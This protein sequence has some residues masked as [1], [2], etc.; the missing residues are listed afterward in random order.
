MPFKLICAYLVLLPFMNLP[1]PAFMA[2]KLQYADLMFIPIMAVYIFK[3]IKGKVRIITDSA[4]VFLLLFIAAAALSFLNSADKRASVLDTL[5]IV[6]LAAMYFVF[7]HF[8]SDENKIRKAAG[9]IFGMASIC[10]ITGLI[11]FVCHKFL[12]AGWA[13]N[14]LFISHDK[15]AMVSSARISSFLKMPEMFTAYML[16][17]LA[18]GFVYR[19][20]L[21]NA[22][23]RAAD[24]IIFMI[25]STCVLSFSR[26]LAG[27]MLFL[28]MAS[29]YFVKGSPWKRSVAVACAGAFIFTFLFAVFTSIFMV[30]PVECRRNG[31]NGSAKLNV[32]LNY[33][34]RVYLAKAA[35]RISAQHPFVG[36]GPGS[37]SARFAQ[38]LDVNETLGLAGA[39]GVNLSGLAVDPHSFYFGTIAELGWP[40]FSIL[41]LFFIILAAGLKGND[42]RFLLLAGILAYMLDGLF[43]DILSIRFFWVLISLYVASVRLARPVRR[44]QRH[45]CCT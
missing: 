11:S 23:R 30:Y 15:S 29:V 21:E 33:D 22:K 36:I 3:A 42:T 35:A 39:M 25:I 34:T 9:L 4:D 16:L 7:T 2:D 8:I 20:Y 17:G 43:L 12:N 6:Y 41:I 24:I 10:A 19:G 38:Y 18:C 27:I 45:L 37:F 1:K 32:N 26:S 14:F 31:I 28:S 13:G 5:G 44:G 40:A